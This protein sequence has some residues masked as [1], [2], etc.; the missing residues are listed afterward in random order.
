M[1][2]AEKIHKYIEV[3]ARG[4]EQYGIKGRRG[5]WRHRQITEHAQGSG[6]DFRGK[7]D[8][9]IGRVVTLAWVLQLVWTR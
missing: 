8:Q 5:G 6:P 2:L 7:G 4:R 9:V 3:F 1:F